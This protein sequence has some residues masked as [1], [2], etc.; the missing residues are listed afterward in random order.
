MLSAGCRIANDP[1]GRSTDIVK[2]GIAA[3]AGWLAAATLGTVATLAAGPLVVAILVGAAASILLDRAD[4]HFEITA[5]LVQAI[6]EMIENRP[7]PLEWLAREIDLW[8]RWMINRAINSS[9]QWR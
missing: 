1:V 3:G 2:F 7:R 4:R 9:M 6:D 5:S 8:E